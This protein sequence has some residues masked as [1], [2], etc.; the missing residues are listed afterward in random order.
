MNRFSWTIKLI[1]PHLFIFGRLNFFQIRK[2]RKEK[3]AKLFFKALAVEDG[4]MEISSLVSFLAMKQR[5][6]NSALV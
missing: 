1:N 3:M 6:V 5:V 2:E 4:Q